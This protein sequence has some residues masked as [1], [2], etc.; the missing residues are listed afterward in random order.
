MLT[1]QLRESIELSSDL[2]LQTGTVMLSTGVVLKSPV[3]RRSQ[4]VIKFLFKSTVLYVLV[5]KRTMGQEY[6]IEMTMSLRKMSVSHWVYFLL[7]L[8]S[9]STAVR[10]KNKQ[11]T[12]SA[13]KQFAL[14]IMTEMVS[15]IMPG[16]WGVQ[17]L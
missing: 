3:M 7:I 13:C 16:T 9:P 11:V 17:T 4:V 2:L 10:M 8:M 6:T 1:K 15:C 12:T 5:M 14:R